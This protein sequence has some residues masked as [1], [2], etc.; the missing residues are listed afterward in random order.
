VPFL[1]NSFMAG[2]FLVFSFF[3]FLDLRGFA[4]AYRSYD[5]LARAVPARSVV[6]PFVEFALGV[7]YLLRINPV[8]TNATTL[9]LMLIG[10]LGV[11][12]TLL[13][14]RTIRCACLGTV[15]K[16][17][18]TTVTLVED[19]GMAVMAAAMLAMLAL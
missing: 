6:Y 11:L 15:I 13:D 19:L 5:L 4:G 12:K 7:A 10:S 3:K 18:M 8:L 14:K 2:F 9:G 17:P 16:L 1:M